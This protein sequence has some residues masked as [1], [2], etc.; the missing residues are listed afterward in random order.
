V[1][2]APR[3]L[4]RDVR[5]A[6]VREPGAFSKD[7]PLTPD[8]IM[9][10]GHDGSVT[11]GLHYAI[12]L[13]NVGP[14][15]DPV[16]LCDLAVA[17]EDAGWDG[18]FLWD[19]LLYADD[20]PVVD[21][22]VTLAAIAAKTERIRLGLCVALLARQLPWEVAKRAVAIDHLAGGRFVLGVGLGS[23]TEEYTAFGQSPDDG[24]RAERLDEALDIVTAAWSGQSF[25]HEGKHFH[26]AAPPMSP[27]PLQRP[28]IP[29]WVGG[30][31]PNR[32]PFRR[33]ARFDGVFPIHKS[34]GSGETMPASELRRVVEYVAAHRNGTPFDVALE[35]RTGPNDGDAARVDEYAR[36]GLTWWVE[37]L[38]WWRGEVS[39]ARQRIKAGP[40]R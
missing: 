23:R 33:A 34:F 36:V 14:F 19:H 20:W 6:D 25:S 12:D 35:G 7:E 22:W 3:E 32:A 10:R 9:R 30:K 8:A 15:A 17:T 26:V 18:F 2:D 1:A 38:G 39:G 40:P 24:E 11:R 27:V 4:Q 28:R 31:W 16:L 5:R 29:I 21:P 37:A 13:P